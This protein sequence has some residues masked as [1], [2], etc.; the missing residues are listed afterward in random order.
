MH[1]ALIIM[2]G[3][4]LDAVA[5]TEYVQPLMKHSQTELIGDTFH[6]EI[7]SAG[8]GFVA[9]FDGRVSSIQMHAE[10]H[11][12]YKQ[13][14]GPLVDDIS[15]GDS[16]LSVRKRLGLPESTGGGDVIPFFGKC[17]KWD[18]YKRQDYSLHISYAEDEKSID[19]ISLIRPDSVPR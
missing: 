7:P 9:S 10:G 2:L 6:M 14:S 13:Y 19:L 15:F 5:Q 8:L 17:T 11:D 12:K 16:Q 18:R 1:N 4:R 3:M